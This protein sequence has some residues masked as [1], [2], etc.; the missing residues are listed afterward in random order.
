MEKEEKGGGL[1]KED[2]DFLPFLLPALGGPRRRRRLLRRSLNVIWSAA[3]G[4]ARRAR[5]RRRLRPSGPAP[6]CWRGGEASARSPG[7]GRRADAFPAGEDLNF[8]QKKK[9]LLRIQIKQKH[10]ASFF[11]NLL[12]INLR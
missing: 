1:A 10:F 2:E 6:S 3:A 7:S 12:C 5:L 4:T 9:Q 8:Q 11:P